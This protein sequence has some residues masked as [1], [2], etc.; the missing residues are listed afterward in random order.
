MTSLSFMWLHLWGSILVFNVL[1]VCIRKKLSW[2][3]IYSTTLF[4]YILEY[5]V[6]SILNLHYHLYG[7]FN[8]GFEYIGLIP[9]FLVYPAISIL[10]LNLYPFHKP[11]LQHVVYIAGWTLFSIVYEWSTVQA[12]WFYYVSW[13]L[14]YSALIYPVLFVILLLN[15]KFTRWLAKPAGHK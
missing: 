12:G 15:Y 14:W 4:A 10:Y 7:Y 6:D 5:T 2:S 11:I 13:K 8:E 9:I 1:A 3:D